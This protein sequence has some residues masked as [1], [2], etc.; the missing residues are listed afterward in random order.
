MAW[1]LTARS[2]QHSTALQDPHSTDGH[3]ATP[4]QRRCRRER[5]RLI[6][7]PAVRFLFLLEAPKRGGYGI[8][9]EQLPHR[10]AGQWCEV[11][12]TKCLVLRSTLNANDA[13]TR[14]VA[15][16]VSQHVLRVS[17]TGSRRVQQLQSEG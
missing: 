10:P 4:F 15:T 6:G 13:V 11:E 17:H 12:R 9:F 16:E 2:F 5:T 8:R 3:I 7:P 14:Q 1:Q